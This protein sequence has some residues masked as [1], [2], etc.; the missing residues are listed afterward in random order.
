MFE[1]QPKYSYNRDIQVKERK[2]EEEKTMLLQDCI[3]TDYHYH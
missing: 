1:I 2:E 3:I